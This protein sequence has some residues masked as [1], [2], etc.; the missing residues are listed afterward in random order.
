[1]V[2]DFFQTLFKGADTDERVVTIPGYIMNWKPKDR[3]VI[4][5]RTTH[6]LFLYYE[7]ESSEIMFDDI[8]KMTE[9]SVLAKACEA[10]SSMMKSVGASDEHVFATRD[11]DLVS[12]RVTS[13]NLVIYDSY[14]FN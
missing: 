2:V 7:N 4:L 6:N 1:M 12:H 14:R 8:Y 3:G 11:G 5:E 13:G 9:S 10:V